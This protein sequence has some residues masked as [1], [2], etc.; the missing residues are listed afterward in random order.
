MKKYLKEILKF[1]LVFLLILLGI[2]LVFSLYMNNI[3]KKNDEFARNDRIS[4]KKNVNR[5]EYE[6]TTKST[7]SVQKELVK[8]PDD[9]NKSYELYYPM[10]AKKKLPLIIWAGDKDLKTTDY[11]K[12][13]ESL[14][15]YGFAV[16]AMEGANLGQGTS[17][18]QALNLMDKLNKDK[19]FSLYKKIDMEN[20]GLGGH[21]QGACEV[22]NASYLKDNHV[23]SIFITSLPK[24]GSLKN[25]FTFKDKS[26][27]SYD[28]TKVSQPIFISAGSGKLDSFYCPLEAISEEIYLVDKN[29]EAYGAIRKKYDNNLVNNYQ[30]LGYMNAWFAY[31]LKKDTTAANAFIEKQELKNNPSWA[32]VKDNR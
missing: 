20:I 1:F 24:L 21:G 19:Y 25:K 28:M 16:I 13:L 12:S 31:S 3:K 10:D 8:D 27:L 11:E 4:Y 23:K 5:I 18:Y 2:G 7:D 22:L 26:N 32:Y 29:V 30:P 6:Y 9:K 17:T 14:S 15:S